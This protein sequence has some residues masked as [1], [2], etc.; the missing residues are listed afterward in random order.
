[1]NNIKKL[2]EL[3]KISDQD[4][5]EALQIGIDQLASWQGGQVMP[6]ASQIEELCLVF[7][8][9]LDQRGN[10]SQ[11]QEHPIHIRLTSDYL[12][13]LGITSSDWISLKWSLEGEWA[14]DQ[15]AVGLFQAGKLVRTVS[16][17]AEFIKAFAGYLILQTRGFYDPYIDEKNNNAQYDWRIIRLATDQNYGDLTPLLTS[18]NP[19]EM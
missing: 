3:T 15:L 4:L 17:N 12:F 9:V 5:A 10:A 6:S 7:S 11:T 19:T 13:N 14:G 18:S 2:Q 8:K 1:M 16:S